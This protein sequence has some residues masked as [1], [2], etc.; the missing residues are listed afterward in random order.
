MEFPWATDAF[1]MDCDDGLLNLVAT[2]CI[3]GAPWDPVEPFLSHL[4]RQIVLWSLAPGVKGYT[5]PLFMYGL[6]YGFCL[7]P[8]AYLAECCHVNGPSGAYLDRSKREARCG[9]LS[10]TFLHQAQ[11]LKARRFSLPQTFYHT[12]LFSDVGNLQA[13]FSNSTADISLEV[14]TGIIT[15][16]TSFVH[17]KKLDIRENTLKIFRNPRTLACHAHAGTF[18]NGSYSIRYLMHGMTR[19]YF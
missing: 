7:L 12:L 17:F 3:G 4:T 18:W 2:C 16:Q 1:D 19:A 6:L 10:S 14:V 11:P 5:H 15:F 9:D 13:M 8:L